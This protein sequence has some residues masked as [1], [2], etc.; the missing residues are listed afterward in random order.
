MAKPLKIPV[1]LLSTFTLKTIEDAI[2]FHECFI[3]HLRKTTY[4]SAI[5]LEKHHIVPKHAGGGDNPENIIR[6]SPEDHVAAHFY[7]YQAY[8]EIGDK[9]AYEM[10]IGDTNERARARAQA[11]VLANKTK[12][13]LFWNSDWQRIQ[14]L[15]G[16][17]VAGSQST[18]AQKAA[19]R[20][21]G[22]LF[23]KQVGLGN[24]SDA[25]KQI[26]S[27]YLEWEFIP[28]QAFF[29]IP[30]ME[31]AYALIRELELLRPGQIINFTSFYKVIHGSRV[32]MYGWRL[33][34][35]EIRSETDGE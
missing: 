30:P 6:I 14:G 15:K 27:N 13:N 28:D 35:V 3:E 17:K 10:R 24:Q 16:G 21:V 7:R 26:L 19:R 1:F 31:S 33:V 2:V 20:K 22:L 29:T 18:P 9:V 23:G 32:K 12:K 5:Q 11:A 34:S 25:L 8:L 4:S